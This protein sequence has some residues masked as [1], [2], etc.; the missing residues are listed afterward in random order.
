MHTTIVYYLL[1]KK[2]QLNEACL[3]HKVRYTVFIR[4]RTRAQLLMIYK[5]SI[6]LCP[7]D[8]RESLKKLNNLQAYIRNYLLLN[9]Q[10]ESTLIVQ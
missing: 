8:E 7:K 4:Q 5:I 2:S 1:K 10:N 6:Y 3:G 9:N